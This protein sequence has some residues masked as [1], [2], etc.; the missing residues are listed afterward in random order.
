MEK[1][2]YVFLSDLQT[3]AEVPQYVVEK[4]SNLSSSDMRDKK[5]AFDFDS[6][7]VHRFKYTGSLKML[8]KERS[9]PEFSS[10]LKLIK[11]SE[12]AEFGNK[13]KLGSVKHNFSFLSE[14]NTEVYKLEIGELVK[15]GSTSFYAA[16]STLEKETFL[17]SEAFLTALQNHSFFND[18]G[19]KNQNK[20]DA[21]DPQT[22]SPQE[23]SP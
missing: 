2:F 17:L 1:K 7:Q 15:K 5:L 22:E 11:E 19:A 6:T 18:V 21:N 13:I 20:K 4:F 10:F 16:R 23:I 14:T 8:E 9:N 12:V 3:L